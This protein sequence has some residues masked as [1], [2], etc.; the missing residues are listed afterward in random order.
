[1]NNE[2][3]TTAIVARGKR[4]NR[5]PDLPYVPTS[6]KD[7]PAPGSRAGYVPPPTYDLIVEM[8]MKPAWDSDH[9]TDEAKA[10]ALIGQVVEIQIDGQ[11]A[12]QVLVK[13]VETCSH[14]FNSPIC[15]GFEAV[16]PDKDPN[17]E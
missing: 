14:G 6:P 17:D 12:G 8:R 2:T 3:K 1:M 13:G 7:A 9:W 16:V 10:L 5:K 11:I 4:I 15:T